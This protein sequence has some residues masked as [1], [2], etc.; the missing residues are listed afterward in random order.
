MFYST[1]HAH[2]YLYPCKEKA[3]YAAELC[4]RNREFRQFYEKFWEITYNPLFTLLSLA[5]LYLHL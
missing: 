3:S 1:L 5:S 2:L 4:G